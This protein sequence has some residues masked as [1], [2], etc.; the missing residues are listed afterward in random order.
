MRGE[1]RCVLVYIL[2]PIHRLNHIGDWGTHFGM[3]IA[4]LKD[5]F[6]DYLHT[7]PPIA[8]LQAFYKVPFTLLHLVL[9]F[10]LCITPYFLAAC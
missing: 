4:H 8:D 3:L 5:K 2:S 9:G 10:M 1:D 6:P 7:S